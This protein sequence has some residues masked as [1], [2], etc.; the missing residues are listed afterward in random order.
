MA[1]PSRRLRH[2]IADLMLGS[3]IS[4]ARAREVFEDAEKAGAMHVS[5][6]ARVGCSGKFRGNMHRD[7]LTKM[8]KKSDWPQ[9]YRASVHVFDRK[10]QLVVSKDIPILLPH[11]LVHALHGKASSAV[12]F[13]TSCVSAAS[14]HDLL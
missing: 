4:A 1:P 5:D 11:E 14:Q 10:T 13:E 7:I 8:L 3:D 9:P 12:L 2:N 6:M